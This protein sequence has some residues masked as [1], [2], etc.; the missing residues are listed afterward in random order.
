MNVHMRSEDKVAT[1]AEISIGTLKKYI[2]YCRMKCGPRLSAAAAEKL[3]DH[4]VRI[5]SETHKMERDSGRRAAIPITVR[6][7][8]ALVRLTESLAKMRLMPFATEEHVEEV[9]SCAISS[10][11]LLA[12]L[13]PSGPYAWCWNPP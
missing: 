3:K 4:F 12:G 6:Q 5:R 7:L 13:R 2:Q 10:R 8:E 1:E 9:S 11:C